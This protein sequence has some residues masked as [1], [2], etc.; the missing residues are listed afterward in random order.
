VGIKWSVND[1]R[2][3]IMRILESRRS[4]TMFNL[5]FQFGVSIRTINYD[6]DSLM[7]SHPIETVRGKG[8]CVKLAE[9][10]RTYQKILSQE[11]Q[12]TLIEI[13][14]LISKRQATVIIGLLLAHGSKPNQKRIDGLIR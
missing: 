12:E 7:S 6:I 8:G 4:E 1:R 14:P 10:Y 11:Q 2:A 9:G 13:I 5:A 3:E